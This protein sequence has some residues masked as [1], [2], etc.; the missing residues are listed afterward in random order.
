MM[1]DGKHYVSAVSAE[2]IWVGDRVIDSEGMRWTVTR[3]L[4]SM[5]VVRPSS[6]SKSYALRHWSELAFVRCVAGTKRIA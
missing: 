2:D 6:N 5:V 3:G 1:I 4:T